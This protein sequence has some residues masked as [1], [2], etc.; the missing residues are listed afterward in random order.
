MYIVYHC[1]LLLFIVIVYHCLLLLQWTVTFEGI[2]LKQDH[3]EMMNCKVVEMTITVG[4]IG[5]QQEFDMVVV[6][7]SWACLETPIVLIRE[8]QQSSSPSLSHAD[9]FSQP[10]VF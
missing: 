6:S 4:R 2:L 10:L 8:L 9:S 1:L 5:L 7:K 3:D